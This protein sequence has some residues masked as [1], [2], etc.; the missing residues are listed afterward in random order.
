MIKGAL[1]LVLAAVFFRIKSVKIEDMAGL[2]RMMPFSMAAFVVAGFSLVG[3]PLTVG[4]VS[5]WYLILGAL[6]KGW[7]P[8]AGLILVSSLLAVIYFWKVIEV[9]YFKERPAEI[10]AI[11]E[12]PAVMLIPMWV[13]VGA[14]IYFGINTGLSVGA[15]SAAAKLLIGG[16]P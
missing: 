1:F 11:S 13:L 7:W 15:A 12:V 9:A 16:A 3:V 14:N 4:F 8:V 2:G 6:E 5:K 10:G